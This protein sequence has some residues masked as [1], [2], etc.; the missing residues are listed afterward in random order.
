MA[1][2]RLVWL[3]LA[4]LLLAAPDLFACANE[5]AG[6]STTWGWI[7]QNWYY[8]V[9]SC[10]LVTTGCWLCLKPGP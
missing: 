1:R 4:V 2:S 9:A 5:M 6:A 8:G 7:R 3:A 10:V